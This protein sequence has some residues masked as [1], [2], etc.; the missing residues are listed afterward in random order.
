[1]KIWYEFPRPVSGAEGFYTRLSANWEKVGNPDTELV[2]KAPKKGTAEFRYSIVGH[3]YA[4]FLRATEMVEG[5]VQAEKE[6]YDGAVI[7]CFGDPG[8]DVLE[9]LVGIPV[10]GPAKAAIITGQIMGSKMVIITLPNFE[11]KIEKLISLYGAQDLFISYRPCRSFDISL[12]QFQEEDR[13]ADNFIK[14][15]REAIGDGADVV[16]LGCCNCSTALT[17]NGITDVDGIPI[18]DGAIA[19]VKLVET[20]VKFKEAGLWRSKKTLSQDIIEGLRK[21]YYHGIE[22]V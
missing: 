11:K 4:D 3:M 9:A 20:M 5:V 14:I 22:S 12:E 8:L 19:A 16:I 10:M 2:I 7:G 21:G 18:V 1:M 15:A 17:Y 13:V 6:G